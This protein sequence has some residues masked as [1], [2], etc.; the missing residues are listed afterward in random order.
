MVN[1]T[2]EMYLVLWLA[3]VQ[4]EPHLAEYCYN[5][6]FHTALRTTPFKVVY[7]RD[8]PH[9]P[10]YVDGSSGVDAVNRALL[11]RDSILHECEPNYSR[12]RIA[13][14]LFMIKDIETLLL[15]W[16]TWYGYVYTLTAKS[17]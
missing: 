9:L 2:I 7:G 16:A 1:R 6:S 3:R 4:H 12:L 8:P 5:I 14:K 11:D 15:M 17:H 10:S 13:L